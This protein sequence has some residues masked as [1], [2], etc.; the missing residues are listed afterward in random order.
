[1][2]NDIEFPSGLY[3][4]R[5]DN[6]PDFVIGQ[7]SIV[8]HKFLEWLAQ[9]DASGKGYVNLDVKRSRDGK[10]YVS[11]NKWK[12]TQQAG[13]PAGEAVMPADD[14]DSDIPF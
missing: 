11:V 9:A 3:F 8:K 5:R 4:D 7:I 12:P 10:L 13:P 1:M 2:S 6:A 14:F